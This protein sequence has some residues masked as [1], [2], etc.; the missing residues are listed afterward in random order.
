M[1][2]V[3]VNDADKDDWRIELS[4]AG[5]DLHWGAVV[6]LVHVQ[7]NHA[8]HL[9]DDSSPGVDNQ[10]EVTATGSRDDNDLWQV[11][12]AVALPAPPAIAFSGTTIRLMHKETN[13]ALHSHRW[14]YS[15]VDSSFQQQ[16][17]HGHLL[18]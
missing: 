12:P 4:E 2:E 8:L 15:H 9:N 18:P 7:T 6:R 1:Q 11:Q 13:H 5:E 17:K 10:L 16:G 14:R 3:T